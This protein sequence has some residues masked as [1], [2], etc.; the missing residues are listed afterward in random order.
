MR[1]LVTKSTGS[2]YIVL[3]EDGKRYTCAIR[4]KFRL[5]NMKITNPIAVGDEVEFNSEEPY[6]IHTIHPRRNY[7][8]RQ[9][10]KKTG[11]GHM[12]SS[13]V[14][15]AILVATISFPRTS[16]GFIDRFLISSEAFRIP[17][18]IVFN[19][20]DLLDEDGHDYLNYIIHIYKAI[21]VQC[22][23]ISCKNKEGLDD[24][25]RLLKGKSSLVA[26]HSGVGKST[27]LNLI[28][29]DIDQATTEISD[30]SEKGKHTTTFA[31]MFFLDDDTKV[32]DTPGIKELGLMEMEDAEICDYFPEMRDIRVGCKFNNCL[33]IHEPHCAI[34]AA[35]ETG[36]ISVERYESYLSILLGDD[37]RR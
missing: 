26:G 37:N 31:E 25:T 22:M 21:G 24:F 29:P 32:I 11:H 17:Q 3:G 5:K 28:H 4:G 36:S 20:T 18:I 15:Q 19:K 6:V 9:S 23:K 1:G 7:I 10:V 13:N 27:L 12:I 8:I 30:F 2:W 16:L 14:D 34:K 35:V 33:H